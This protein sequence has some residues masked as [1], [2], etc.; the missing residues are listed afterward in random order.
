MTHLKFCSPIMGMEFWIMTKQK[1][2]DKRQIE[3]TRSN[4]PLRPCTVVLAVSMFFCMPLKLA[5][6]TLFLFL[7][8]TASVSF[9]GAMQYWQGGTSTRLRSEHDL[10]RVVRRVIAN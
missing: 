4:Y 7:T 3:T 2:N 1:A 10:P 9:G 8:N 6:A 5:K